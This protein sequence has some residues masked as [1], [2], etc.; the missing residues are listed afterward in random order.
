MVRDRAAGSAGG[1]GL[2][3][4]G[5]LSVQ[6]GSA[7]AALLFPVAGAL[8][9]VTLR[10]AIAAVLLLVVCR[11]RMRGLT[12]ADWAVAAAFGVALGG[13][14]ILFYQAIDRIPMGTAVTLEVLGPL[15]MSIAASRRWLSLVWAGS[16]LA[17]VFLLGEGGLGRLDL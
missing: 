17:G 3:L 8:G 5:A 15:V 4:A 6:F 7:V 12:R 11:P 14:N 13:M 16:A 2:V 9:V 1:I 10:V